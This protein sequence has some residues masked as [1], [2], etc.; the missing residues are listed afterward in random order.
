MRGA[1]APVVVVIQLL[2]P[3][4]NQR[5]VGVLQAPVRAQPGV[6]GRNGCINATVI[7]A[8]RRIHFGIQNCHES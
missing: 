4:R 6:R 8:K 2:G 3:P 5:G 7:I 1:E